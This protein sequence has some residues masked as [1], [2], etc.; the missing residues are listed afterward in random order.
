MLMA[1]GAKGGA[2]A[3][4]GEGGD[5]NQHP[6]GVIFGAWEGWEGREE[7]GGGVRPLGE[8]CGQ[9]SGQGLASP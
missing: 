6:G 1:A 8:G 3:Q 2:R 9:E 4:E 7:G 5:C